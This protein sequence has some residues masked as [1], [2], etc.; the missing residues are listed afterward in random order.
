MSTVHRLHGIQTQEISFLQCSQF[1]SC[2]LKM[3]QIS[4]SNRKLSE[5]VLYQIPALLLV[6]ISKCS[7]SRHQAMPAKLEP[8]KSR[9]IF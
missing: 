7:V 3:I 8:K 9:A 5:S 1:M 6:R 4:H 2:N